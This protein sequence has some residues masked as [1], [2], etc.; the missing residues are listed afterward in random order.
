MNLLIF[1]IVINSIT[2][3]S[4]EE[5]ADFESLMDQLE[6]CQKDLQK[7][8]EKLLQLFKTKDRV[9]DE[10]K[11]DF[12][13]LKNHDR[14]QCKIFTCLSCDQKMAMYCLKDGKIRDD[15]EDYLLS[16]PGV[17][18]VSV[19]ISGYYGGCDKR[20]YIFVYLNRNARSKFVDEAIQESPFSFL[21]Q[22]LNYEWV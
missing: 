22:Y 16:V 4:A 11:I 3:M 1:I 13:K 21:T 18:K 12:E 17:Y 5:K 15:V 10:T 19:G 2:I 20:Q 14:Y 9:V 8:R 7:C 6:S